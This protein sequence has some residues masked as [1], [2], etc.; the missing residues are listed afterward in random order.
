MAC[1]LCWRFSF[2]CVCVPEFQVVVIKQICI[3]LYIYILGL[4]A[5][6]TVAI[7]S[8]TCYSQESL[9]I[10]FEE[11]FFLPTFEFLG[12]AVLYEIIIPIN[13]V[14]IPAIP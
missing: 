3:H 13:I 5:L 1:I 12:D 6:R 11:V 4:M 8:I 14:A 9:S 2:W 7:P 10:V